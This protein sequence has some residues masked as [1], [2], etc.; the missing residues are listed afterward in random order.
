MEAPAD[1]S[2]ELLRLKPRV[3]DHHEV[4]VWGEHMHEAAR[5]RGLSGS[6]LAREDDEA[7]SLGDALEEMAER[8]YMA[9][10]HIEIL[11]VRGNGEGVLLETEKFVIHRAAVQF[12][13]SG[14]GTMRYKGIIRATNTPVSNNTS[15]GNRSCPNPQAFCR[16]PF[17]DEY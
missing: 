15:S 7:A 13:S 1:L 4:G 17:Q 5:Y 10:A 16:I 11:G 3:V 12:T 6:D 9:L 8:F 2:E 14:A